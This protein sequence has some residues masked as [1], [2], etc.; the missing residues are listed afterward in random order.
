M[1]HRV[2]LRWAGTL[3]EARHLA[4]VRRRADVGHWRHV[5]G[6][7]K[8]GF[9]SL[10][11]SD[12]L[13]SPLGRHGIDPW[14]ALAVAAAET[15]RLTLGTLVSPITFYEP[16]LARMAESLR[17][18]SGG[19]FTLGSAWAGTPTSTCWR[20]EFPQVGERAR[21][22]RATTE[23]VK[24]CLPLLIGGAGER[25]TLPLVAEFADEWNL[26]TSSVEAYAAKPRHARAT[27]RGDRAAIE[28]DSTF[29]GR[30]HAHRPR[31]G[32]ARAT[33]SG[34][35]DRSSAGRRPERTRDR[36]AGGA[37][38]DIVDASADGAGGRGACHPRP[39]PGR[40]RRRAG[41][42]RGRWSVAGADEVRS[43]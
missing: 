8:L 14:L 4:G 23:R 16:Q 26:T 19:R 40:R 11:I 9:E 18:L 1:G 5:V 10:W 36:L 27:V 38:D 42:N 33:L 13:E 39:L 7:A 24:A 35:G 17:A 21:R 6:R 30:G 32:R 41:A 15:E 43:R 3:S 28:R 37:P 12:H 29:G 25:P 20:I 2:G 22:L 34:A 31:S